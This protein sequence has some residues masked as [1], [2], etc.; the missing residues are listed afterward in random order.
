MTGTVTL[1]M[2]I[3][4]GWGTHDR[5]E[6][7]YFSPDAS[8]ESET[9][10]KLLDCCDR[11][12]IP[13]SFDVVGHLLHD[14]CSGEH[15]GPH[16]DSWWTEDPGTDHERD[17]LFYAPQ[18]IERI[19]QADVDHEIC[20]HTYSHILTETV[21]EEIV[22]DEIQ[23][24]SEV[25]ETF[26]LQTPQ[27]IVF[28]RHQTP[29]LEVLEGTDIEIIR[30][31]MENYHSPS[32]LVRKFFWALR[33][34]HPVTAVDDSGDVFETF[35]TPHPSLSTGLLPVG[36]ESEHPL[37][38]LIPTVARQKVHERYLRSAVENAA[39]TGEYVHLWSHLFNIANDVQWNPIQ[40]GLQHIAERRDSGEITVQTMAELPESKNE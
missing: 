24:A 18:L 20:T 10:T 38:R 30:R 19:Q 26:G 3:E 25:H 16:P 6:Y 39:T 27:S 22:V 17:P 21:S 28:P 13:I 4:L 36:Q 15:P 9:L 34:T 5:A 14:S 37:L 40:S 7:T 33:R 29:S 12:E 8:A 32:G 11:Y 1:S 2:E 31:P 35:C 23:K